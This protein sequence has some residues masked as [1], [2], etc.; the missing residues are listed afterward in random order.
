MSRQN[1]V[2]PV[3]IIKRKKI[4]KGGGHHGGAWKVAY[5]DFVT[6][7]MAFFLMMWLLGATTESQRRGLADY[8][9]PS[10]PVHRISSG[11]EGMFGG[12]DFE[13]RVQDG[14]ASPDDDDSESS[15]SDQAEAESFAD[16]QQRL[17]GL[18]GESPVL[19]NALRHIVTRQTD[20]GLVL[21]VFDLPGAPLFD[22]DSDEPTAVTRQIMLVLSQVF[23]MVINPLAIEGHTR[24]YTV[25]QANDP[26]WTLSMA[27]AE[28]ARRLL[29]EE[30][31]DATRMARVTGH[32]D[33]RPSVA[34]PM[35]VRNNRLELI[36][37]RRTPR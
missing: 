12:T 35:A 5:A 29:D 17:N 32:A 14:P 11:G 6:A 37:L 10:I 1:D 21:E 31:F 24:T 22:N 7:M 20:E 18:G 16:L 25:V 15:S 4:V 19:D 30:G 34:N 26:R 2:A 27:R 28:M 9:N 3:I 36:L 23:S 8:F 33:R 13:T